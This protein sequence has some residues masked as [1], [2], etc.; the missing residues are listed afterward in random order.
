MSSEAHNWLALIFCHLRLIIY[1]VVG[2]NVYDLLVCCW[3]LIIP[4]LHFRHILIE[5]SW[6]KLCFK[7]CCFSESLEQFLILLEQPL[8]LINS[9][10]DSLSVNIAISQFLSCLF[11]DLSIIKL[12]N[13]LIFLLEFIFHL[14]IN[15][16]GV[17][18]ANRALASFLSDHFINQIEGL[19]WKL[20]KSKSLLFIN[21]RV[22]H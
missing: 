12:E 21:I 17:I 8:I 16:L 10:I 22:H 20:N 19:D 11:T 4:T 6:L 7:G 1:L 3:G 14:K 2:R 9:M 5:L 18:N 15:D 13:V